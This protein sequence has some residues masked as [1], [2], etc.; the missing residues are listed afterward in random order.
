MLRLTLVACLI[1][2]CWAA[3]NKITEFEEPGV[4]GG[5]FIA[6]ILI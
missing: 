6:K 5:N 4:S 2:L 1:G 3:D